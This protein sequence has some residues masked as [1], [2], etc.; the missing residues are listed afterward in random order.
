MNELHIRSHLRGPAWHE[1]LADLAFVVL[2]VAYGW[3]VIFGH[4]TFGPAALFVVLGA[5]WL[6]IRK[7]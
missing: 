7:F 5:G 3:V 6:T 4:A 1:R 2:V